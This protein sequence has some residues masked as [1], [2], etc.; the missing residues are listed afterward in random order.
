MVRAVSLGQQRSPKHTK[1]AM[2]PFKNRK[3]TEEL[4]FTRAKSETKRKTL[5]KPRSTISG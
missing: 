2:K 1:K 5:L 3:T 4:R